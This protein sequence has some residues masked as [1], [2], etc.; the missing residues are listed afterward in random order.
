MLRDLPFAARLRLRAL[1]AMG[2]R[3]SD[4]TQAQAV[5]DELLSS[6]WRIGALTV[7]SMTVFVVAVET[8][9]DAIGTGVN[10]GELL[11]AL[12]VGFVIGCVVFGRI[13]RRAKKQ[14][15]PTG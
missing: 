8:V 4:S 10:R 13:L 7:L 14:S 12:V 9:A 3:I 1:A 5:R 11:V 15:T 2:L 6:P